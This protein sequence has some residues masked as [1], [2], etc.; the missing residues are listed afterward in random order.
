M[1][2]LPCKLAVCVDVLMRCWDLKVSMGDGSIDSNC[3]IP[4]PFQ[5]K[6]KL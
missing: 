2:S 5:Y 6:V 1:L 4:K 3:Y